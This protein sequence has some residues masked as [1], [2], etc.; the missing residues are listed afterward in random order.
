CARE[1]QSARGGNPQREHIVTVPD[2]SR[3]HVGQMSLE[4]CWAATY[5]MLLSYVGYRATEAD[6]LE[7]RRKKQCPER[8]GVALDCR[9]D[10]SATQTEATSAALGLIP[11]TARL[12]LNESLFDHIDPLDLLSDG[13]PFALLHVP[14]HANVGHAYLVEGARY[15]VESGGAHVV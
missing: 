12:D 15:S 1:D 10:L 14:P 11:G 2:V 8:G 7:L 13:L 4:T 3:V 5:A 9:M 6:L